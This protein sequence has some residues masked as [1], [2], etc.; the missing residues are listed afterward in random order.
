MKAYPVKECKSCYH[1]WISFPT[2]CCGLDTEIQITERDKTHPDCLLEDYEPTTKLI[3]EK[4]SLAGE[5]Y[6]TEC[7]R[8]GPITSENYCDHCG[9]KIKK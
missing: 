5:V 9:K 6:L 2:D 3:K 4:D 8:I 1:F 7:C